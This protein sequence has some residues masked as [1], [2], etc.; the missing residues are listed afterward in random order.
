MKRA[1]TK[2]KQYTIRKIPPA[3]DRALPK[4]A[5]ANGKSLNDTALEALCR[6]VG[7]EA[8]AQLNEFRDIIGTWVED[9]EF[10]R[11]LAA[12]DTI[13]PELWR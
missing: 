9:P 3:V 7:I 6:A 2:A 5:R 13:D 1:R 11:A 4:Q 10:D 8:T 12:Q